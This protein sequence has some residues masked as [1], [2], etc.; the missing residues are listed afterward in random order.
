MIYRKTILI[1]AILFAVVMVS[2]SQAA[3]KPGDYPKKPIRLIVP[4][5]AGGGTDMA[6]RMLASVA[7]P[8]IGQPVIVEVRAGGGGAVGTAFAA[9]ATP[10]GYTLY[11]ATPGPLSVKPQM[12]K[13]PYTQESFI[14]ILQVAANSPVLISR[15]KE[16]WKNLGEFIE[17][18]KANPEAV[19][20]GHPGVGSFL[21]LT[22]EFAMSR[23]DIQVT[24][25]PFQGSAP[26]Q[27]ALVGGHIDITVGYLIDVLSLIEGKEAIAL[28]V[29]SSERLPELPDT[30][31]FLEKN[32]DVNLQAW[33]GVF[34]IKGTPPKIVQYLHEAFKKII[35]SED[36]KKLAKKIGENIYYRN[37]NDLKKYWDREYQ[38]VGEIL[39][40]LGLKIKE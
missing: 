25:V 37:G 11:M 2:S 20:Y 39:D 13:V 26:T 35:E 5:S 38:I 18:T 22:G 10:D 33:R 21:D 29:S 14:P 3:E 7:E 24:K 31:T 30:P 9:R 4:F 36:Y 19:K 32:Y 17:Y 23:M 1:V 40:S 8:L 12:Q 28:A 16:P 34:A 27:A 15:V 6:A